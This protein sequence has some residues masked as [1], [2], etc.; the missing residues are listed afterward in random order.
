MQSHRELTKF[1]GNL[2]LYKKQW[3]NTYNTNEKA[4]LL[5]QKKI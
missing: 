5:A 1:G 3:S 2:L 4:K